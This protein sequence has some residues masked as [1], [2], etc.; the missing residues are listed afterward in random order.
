[1]EHAI[2]FESSIGDVIAIFNAKLANYKNNKQLS[3]TTTSRFILNPQWDKT[4]S[5][6]TWYETEGHYIICNM[7]HAPII[8]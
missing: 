3:L 5:L 6:K 8:S 4:T 7:K 1:M 2:K